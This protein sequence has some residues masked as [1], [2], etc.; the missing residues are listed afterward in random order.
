MDG[1]S[2]WLCPVPELAV[3]SAGRHDVPPVIVELLENFADFRRHSLLTMHGPTAMTL[4]CGLL[5][6]GE[7][8]AG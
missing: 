5:G 4:R 7:E 6:S 8:L 3:T 1:N 2:T